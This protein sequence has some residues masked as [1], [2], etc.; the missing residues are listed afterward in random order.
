MSDYMV[1]TALGVLGALVVGLLVAVVVLARRRPEALPAVDIDAAISGIG[2]RLAQERGVFTEKLDQVDRKLAL[3][4]Q[5]VDQKE[6]AVQAQ[7]QTIGKQ[8]QDISSIFK[9]DRQ[10]GSWGEITLTRVFEAAGMVEGRDYVKQFT[11]GENRPDVI[12]QLPDDHRIVIDSKFPL[13]RYLEAM[14]VE[15]ADERQK[16]LRGHGK[17]LEGVARNLA[18]KYRDLGTGGYVVMYVPS[19]D[20]FEAAVEADDALVDRLME[21]NVIVAG[22]VNVFA[23]LKTVAVIAAQYRA[24]S[25]AQVI[26]DQVKELRSRLGKF[27]EHFGKVGKGLLT[28]VTSFNQAVGSWNTRL[29]PTVT[30]I[31]EMSNQEDLE[32]MGEIHEMPSAEPMVTWD[33]MPVL[34]GVLRD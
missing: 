14:A 22:P 13:Q 1:M 30:R 21:M 27:T 2:E 25:E 10:R 8:M 24:A 32:P 23:L 16:L 11:E 31:T 19:Q 3:L 9:S 12:V 7:I 15:D 34:E 20:V 4:Q 28:A 18:R 6:G 26:L 29:A 33:D 5:V 17:E